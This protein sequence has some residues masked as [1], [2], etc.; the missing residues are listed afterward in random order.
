MRP[1]I[2]LARPLYGPR[3]I[4]Q[5]TRARVDILSQEV[6]SGRSSDLGRAL[7]SDFS[8]LSRLTNALTVLDGTAHS[9]ARAGTWGEGLQR[10]LEGISGGMDLLTEGLAAGL[11]SADSPGF[12]PDVA[13]GSLRDMAARLNQ[14]VSDRALFGNGSAAGPLQDVDGLLADIRALASGAADYATYAADID[15]YFAPGG[16]YETT[17][18]TLGATDPVRFPAGDGR[19]VGFP[20][21]ATDPV[22]VQAVAQVALVAGLS[23]AAFTLTPASAATQDMQSRLASARGD[24]PGL[25]GRVGAVEQRVGDLISATDDRRARTEMDLG[26]MIGI[27][28]FEAASAL[29]NEF[30]RLES[31]YAITARRARLRLTD[32]L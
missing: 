22:L 12:A 29:Q 13:E 32:Y 1:E 15:A 7:S 5:E 24:L 8:E 10:A 20:V 30:A 19:S 2:G 9:L 4:T 3:D 23:D 16:A 28:G 31:L 11:A 14:T 27:D 6:A 17:R 25:H 18:L 26:E 21:D